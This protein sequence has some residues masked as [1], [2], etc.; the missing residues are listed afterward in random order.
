MN[1]KTSK[2]LKDVAQKAALLEAKSRPDGA[3]TTPWEK[4]YGAMKRMFVKLSP[5]DKKN[6]LEE[7]RRFLNE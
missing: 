2:I 6:L 5:N 1:G 7:M 3:V 4:N